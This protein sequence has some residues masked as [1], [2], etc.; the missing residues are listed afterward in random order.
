LGSCFVGQNCARARE[1]CAQS[2]ALVKLRRRKLKICAGVY[3]GVCL[4]AKHQKKR[5][6]Q[7]RF[8]QH[9]QPSSTRVPPTSRATTLYDS[10]T[11]IL[12]KYCFACAPF[13]QLDLY[14]F[15]PIH[16][17]YQFCNFCSYCDFLLTLLNWCAAQLKKHRTRLTPP[18]LA[19]PLLSAHQS[20]PCCAANTYSHPPPP[21]PYPI[22]P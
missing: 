7:P 15:L 1:Q 13:A 19:I 8:S 21:P 6:R 4:F 17:E 22:F 11:H 10:T 20:T 3:F 14:L 2:A 18:C 5:E 12:S 9:C 16:K